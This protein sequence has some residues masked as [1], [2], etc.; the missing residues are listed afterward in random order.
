M[1]TILRGVCGALALVG[2]QVAP[3]HAADDLESLFD[4]TLGTELRKAPAPAA[5]SVPL[6]R[7]YRNPTV[8]QRTYDTPFEATLASMASPDMGRIGVAAMDLSTGRSVAVLGDQP[9]PMAST[10]KVAIVATFLEGVDQGRWKLSDQFPLMVPIPSKKFAGS[11]APVRA[12][13]MFSAQDLIEMT[14]TRSNN[15]ATDALL[16]VVGGPRAVNAWLRR[17]DV[18]GIRIDRDIATL[19]RD[20]GAVNPATTVD[21]RDSA[22]PMGMIRLL[23]GIY[24]GQWL[25][26]SSRQVLLGAMERCITGKGRIRAGMPEG[27]LVA[28]KTGTLNNTAS[29]IGFIRAPDG[30]TMAVAIYVTGQGGKPNRDARIASIA[31]TIYDGYQTEAAGLRRSASR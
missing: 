8:P 17:A 7:E 25:S 14:I 22:T 10:S 9:F 16:A 18:Q 12:G 1:N 15:Q 13:A 23:H 30:R 5:R 28:H 4:G 24:R 6:L 20:D 29:D 3:A 27:T 31:R 19:V 21:Q 11:V 26:P 2:A